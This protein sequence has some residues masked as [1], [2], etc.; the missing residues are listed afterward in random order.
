MQDSREL[1]RKV[2]KS[3]T[4][5]K[6]S[7]QSTRTKLLARIAGKRDTPLEN[8]PLS[9]EMELPANRAKKFTRTDQ[10]K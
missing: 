6:P 1:T 8:V 7:T 9:Q 4:M 10:F 2:L 3:Q 5:S